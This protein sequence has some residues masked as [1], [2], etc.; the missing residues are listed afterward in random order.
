MKK[1]EFST[2]TIIF[3]VQWTV[4]L[5]IKKI[6]WQGT[7]VPSFKLIGLQL[8]QKL[9]W[10]NTFTKNLN[11]KRDR[12]T[13]EMWG[14][15]WLLIYVLVQYINIAR[16][17]INRPRDH[18]SYLLPRLLLHQKQNLSCLWKSK[19]LLFIIVIVIIWKSN[20][21]KSIKLLFF[22]EETFRQSRQ[23]IRSWYKFQNFLINKDFLYNVQINL[24]MLWCYN[25]VLG[26]VKVGAYFTTFK[27]SAVLCTCP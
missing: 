18:Y 3:Y 6:T 12:L 26:W 11:L 13:D 2:R 5:K 23:W 25:N 27:N 14:I 7:Y 21:A 4:K 9:I 15:T 20:H 24:S 19:L 10:P 22:T 8:R 17:M 16:K 1:H